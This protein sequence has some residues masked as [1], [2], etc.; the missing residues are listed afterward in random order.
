M[1][2]NFFV[3][4][5]STTLICRTAPVLSSISKKSLYEDGVPLRKLYL[6]GALS[7]SISIA[8]IFSGNI[9]RIPASFPL[10]TWKSWLCM[11]ICVCVYIYIYIYIR[12]CYTRNLHNYKRDTMEK[13]ICL[14]FTCCIGKSF[15]C[16]TSNLALL[17]KILKL[18][19]IF[20]E[21]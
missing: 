2:S 16:M 4:L 6:I 15:S 18:L 1:I 9:L 11:Y 3:M 20:I 7:E 21:Y 12:I 8:C 5:V 17:F 13:I 10:D 14:H 19:I